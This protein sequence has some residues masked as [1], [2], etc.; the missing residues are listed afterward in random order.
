MIAFLSRREYEPF[1]S[2]GDAHQF[3]EVEE[4][5]IRPVTLDFQRI[6][7]A[8]DSRVRLMFSPDGLTQNPLRRK[9]PH[10][11]KVFEQVT[12]RLPLSALSER[13]SGTSSDREQDRLLASASGW[14][15]TGYD[16]RRVSRFRARNCAS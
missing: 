8:H 11:V 3:F 10:T 15:V 16:R 7:R 12:G 9:R 4:L 14:R 2:N 6:E 5:R 13:F 1:I